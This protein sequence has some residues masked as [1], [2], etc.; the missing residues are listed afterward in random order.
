MKFRLTIAAL[1][2]ALPAV[3]LQA[4]DE[5]SEA[6]PAE[7]YRA[8]AESIDAD[9]ATELAK[10]A[11]LREQIAAEKPQAA[12][13]GNDIAEE[14]REKRHLA[15]IARQ[16]SDAL[17][18]ELATVDQRIRLWRDEGKYIDSLLLDFRKQYEAQAGAAGYQNLSIADDA[19]QNTPLQ[20]AAQRLAELADIQQQGGRV[21]SGQAVD[22]A[23]EAIDGSFVEV[24]PLAWFAAENGSLAGLVTEGRDLRPQVVDGTGKVGQLRALATG[25]E[26]SPVFDPTL[27]SA[28]ALSEADTGF[29]EHIRQGGLWIYPILLL[30]LIAIVSALVKWLQIS[31]IRD[32]SPMVVR[33]VID[34]VNA[35]DESGAE[36]AVSEMNHPAAELLRRGIAAADQPRE[37]VEES[38]YEEYIAAQPALQ[39]GLPLIAIASATAPLLGLLGTVTGMIATFQ[40]IRIFGTSDTNVIAGGISE[41]LVTTECGLAVAIPAVIIH[42][43]LSRRVQGIR[44]AMEMTSLAF[45]NGLENHGRGGK[46]ES[47]R[48]KEKAKG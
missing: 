46:G 1:L 44:S 36:A 35:G 11:K 3:V 47:A 28:L 42:A 2:V 4:Q 14:L 41:A 43:L 31:R 21:V 5:T 39:R 9:L 37:F 38:L 7:A 27:G 15:E 29:V 25:S 18:H 17:E 26:V 48:S 30:A 16:K 45:V 13:A 34:A 8:A 23:G 22:D 24:G 6:D 33:R 40:R 12:K 32:V 19:G 20:L 10:L